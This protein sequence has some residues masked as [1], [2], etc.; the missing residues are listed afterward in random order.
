M[1]SVSPHISPEPVEPILLTRRSRAQNLKHTASDLKPDI[2]AN[3]FAAR[4]QSSQ[5]T[6]PGG[7]NSTPGS[8]S[9]R[10][11]VHDVF[12]ERRAVLPALAVHGGDL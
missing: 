7:R 11:A 4:D 2:R 1:Q 12:E 10:A 5:L 3:D 8:Q 9:R 6:A